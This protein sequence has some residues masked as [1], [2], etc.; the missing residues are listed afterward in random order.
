MLFR[1]S[2]LVAV[3]VSL[4]IVGS[5]ARAEE[6]RFPLTVD[7]E[8]IKMALRQHLARETGGRLELWRSPD[9]CGSFALDDPSIEPAG[10]RLRIVGPASGSAGLSLFGLCWATVAWSGRAEVTARPE[11]GPDWQLRL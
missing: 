10:A 6:I 1:L 4:L 9:G 5:P 11:I 7:Y 8:I 2:L 3:P